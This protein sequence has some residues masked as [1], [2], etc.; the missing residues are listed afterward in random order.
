MVAASLFLTRRPLCPPGSTAPS[1]SKLWLN[2]FFFKKFFWLNL[3]YLEMPFLRLRFVAFLIASWYLQMVSFFLWRAGI[4]IQTVR[5][6]RILPR[7]RMCQIA[8]DVGRSHNACKGAEHSASA[9][10]ILY[11]QNNLNVVSQPCAILRSAQTAFCFFWKWRSAQLC[12]GVAVGVMCPLLPQLHSVPFTAS[13]KVRQNIQNSVMS[14]HSV[15]KLHSSFPENGMLRRFMF[16]NSLKCNKSKNKKLIK[17]SASVFF[18]CFPLL[19]CAA[20][21]WDDK[22][23]ETEMIFYEMC[24]NKIYPNM[25]SSRRGNIAVGTLSINF[26]HICLSLLY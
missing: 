16:K 6:E 7:H 3:V 21:R 14:V 18:S 17:R 26:R 2:C 10:S 13:S 19:L 4:K 11:S 24:L 9:P 20:W 23:F 12:I 25:P 15:P 1:P 8:V 5:C 22:T